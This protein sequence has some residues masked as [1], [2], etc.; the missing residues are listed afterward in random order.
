MYIHATHFFTPKRNFVLIFQNYFIRMLDAS[1]IKIK[2]S[3]SLNQ[4]KLKTNTKKL[5]LYNPLIKHILAKI[6][7]NYFFFVLLLFCFCFVFVFSTVPRKQTKN[8]QFCQLTV[9]KG[10]FFNCIENPKHIFFPSC[11]QNTCHLFSIV[12]L[13]CF[14]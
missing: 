14:L 2:N 7:I 5:R 11:K 8:K 13:F 12:R 4:G 9:L 3:L 6:K 1:S 10:F